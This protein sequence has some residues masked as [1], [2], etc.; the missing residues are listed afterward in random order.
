MMSDQNVEK[1]V[2][3]SVIGVVSSIFAGA[4]ARNI[5]KSALAISAPVNPIVGAIGTTAL[6]LCIENRVEKE[7]SQMA[8]E[9]LAAFTIPKKEAE[10]VEK[11]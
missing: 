8:Q 11:D 7:I 4:V 5:I 9:L 1:P 3:P 2:A 6:C 10:S